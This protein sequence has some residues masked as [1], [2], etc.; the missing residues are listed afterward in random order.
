MRQLVLGRERERERERERV[1]IGHCCLRQEE[2][3]E[4]KERESDSSIK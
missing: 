1:K 3:E 4:G 2:G